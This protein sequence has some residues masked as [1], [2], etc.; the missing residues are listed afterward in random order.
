MESLQ[1]LMDN[2]SIIGASILAFIAGF[3]KIA[4]VGIKTLANIRDAWRAS[5]PKKEK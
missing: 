1:F 2:L 5:F 4:L 3:D